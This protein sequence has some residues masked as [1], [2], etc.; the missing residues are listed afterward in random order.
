LSLARR[1]GYRPPDLAI[2]DRRQ[3]YSSAPTDAGGRAGRRREELT[4]RRAIPGFHQAPGGKF[5]EQRDHVMLAD[6][7]GDVVFGNDSVTDFAD[8]TGLGD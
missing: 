1:F 5:A 6:L 7:G 4:D 2:F 3:C 8:A